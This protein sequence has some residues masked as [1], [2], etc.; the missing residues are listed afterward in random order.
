MPTP[1]D[2]RTY[3][4]ER[5]RVGVKEGSIHYCGKR[6][7]TEWA[8]QDFYHLYYCPFCGA[9]VKG[10]GWGD[11]DKKYPPTRPGQPNLTVQRTKARGARPGR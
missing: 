7:E 5:F 10:T 8:V 1:R 3:C 4:C 2:K 6:D 11:Y 9:F